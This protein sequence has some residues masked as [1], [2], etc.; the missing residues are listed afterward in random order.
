MTPPAGGAGWRLERVAAPLFVLLWSTGFIGARLGLPYAEPLTFLTVR[1]LI[2]SAVLLLALAAASLWRARA[3]PS[4]G[5]GAGGAGLDRLAWGRLALIGALN[6]GGYLGGTFVAISWGLEAGLAALIASLT[7]IFTAVIARFRFGETL[8]RAQRIGMALGFLGVALVVWRKLGAGLGD[9][10]GVAMSVLGALAFAIGAV[11]Q[12][13]LGRIP[14]AAGNAV[15]YLSAAALCG[16]GAL[17]LEDRA[18][19][20]SP[21]F[22]FAL[23][24]LVGALSIGAITLYYLLL[25][26]RAA[27]EAAS[28][29][30]LAPGCT[31]LMAYVLF[32]EL[33]GPIEILGLATAS[34]GVA[35]VTRSATPRA[36]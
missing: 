17:L 29:F 33:F 7:P 34:L 36:A 31:A 32:G 21:S 23:V 16:I 12:R 2:V 6:H 20:W 9:V 25:Q 10:S 26:R 3:A 15:Q 27:A 8:S 5:A 1:F 4:P 11:E 30:F 35:L 14:L 13:G 22:I 24:W 18:I 28:L 19:I